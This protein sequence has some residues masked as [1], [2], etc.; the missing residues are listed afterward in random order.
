MRLLAIALT[1][2]DRRGISLQ[3]VDFQ[4]ELPDLYEQVDFAENK[5][6]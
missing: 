5:G 4:I 2:S 6:D 1:E 3:T